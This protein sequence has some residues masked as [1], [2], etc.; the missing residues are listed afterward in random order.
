[1]PK[2][3]QLHFKYNGPFGKEM[4]AQ[5][6]ELA[7]SINHEPGFIWKIWT[8]NEKTKEAGGIYLF[9]DEISAQNYVRKHAVRLR[10]LGINE[11]VFKIFEV[12]KAL[13][14]INKFNIL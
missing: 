4:S 11:I 9:D 13:S 14:E 8:E 1:M 7:E 5:L 2:L 12:N 3:L 10:P 6:T